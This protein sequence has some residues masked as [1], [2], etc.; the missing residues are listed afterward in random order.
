[1]CV[2]LYT[3]LVEPLSWFPLLGLSVPF[4]H[5]QDPLFLAPLATKM[6]FL[7]KDSASYDWDLLLCGIISPSL[8]IVH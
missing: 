3:E 4:F 8:S 6:E 1:M 7:L 5:L 2:D